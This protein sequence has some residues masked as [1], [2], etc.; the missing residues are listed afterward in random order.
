VFLFSIPKHAHAVTLNDYSP[1]TILNTDFKIL[2]RLLANQLRP[3][4]K[5]L[6]HQDQHCE[7]TGT[8][9]YDALGTVRDVVPFAEHTRTYLC[10]VSI[11]SRVPLITWLMNT[12]TL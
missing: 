9:V 10:L 5:D 2:T 12:W 1:I 4:M 7:L 8:N 6:L 3:W 11:I